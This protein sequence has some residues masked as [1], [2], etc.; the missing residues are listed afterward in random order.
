LGISKEPI[1]YA[2]KATIASIPLRSL[3]LFELLVGKKP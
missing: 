1:K 3:K 2:K